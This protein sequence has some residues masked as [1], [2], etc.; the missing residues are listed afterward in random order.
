VGGWE[1]VGSGGDRRIKIFLRRDIKDATRVNVVAFQPL[2]IGKQSRSVNLPQIV[3][4]NI[5]NE[6]GTIGVYSESYFQIRP[7]EVAGAIQIDS[8]KFQNPSTSSPLLKIAERTL[9]PQWAYR[10]S[11]RPLSFRF[12]VSR[13]QAEKQAIAEHAVL[14]SPRKMSLSSRVRYQLKGIPE[15]TFVIELPE[16][17]LVLNVNAE[18]LDDWYVVEQNADD[19]R[20]LVLE[21]KELK[22]KTGGTKFRRGDFARGQPA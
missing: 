16:S 19:M 2:S 9:S 6:T 11:R 7:E 5:T 21:F 10:F 18:G 14:V 20:V 13:R 22:N 17:Y 12:A 4:E 3:P 1:I 8:R 15:S